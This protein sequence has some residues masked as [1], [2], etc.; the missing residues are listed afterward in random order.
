MRAPREAPGGPRGACARCCSRTERGP[1]SLMPGAAPASRRGVPPLATV[2]GERSRSPPWPSRR[3]RPPG[4]SRRRR[5][6]RALGRLPT[7]RSLPERRARPLGLAKT[8]GTIAPRCG[9]VAACAERGGAP[10][11]WACAL[12]PAGLGAH[13]PEPVRRVWPWAWRGCGASSRRGRPRVAG[14][15]GAGAR[16]RARASHASRARVQS[17]RHTPPG[18]ARPPPGPCGWR[19]PGGR[20]PRRPGAGRANGCA[21]RGRARTAPDAERA[22]RAVWWW[23]RR[24]PGRRRPPRPRPP[25]TRRPRQP[26]RRPAS[27]C[28]PGGVR[29]RRRWQRPA[30]RRRAG[31]RAGGAAAH[32]RGGLR[33]D[34]RASW[35]RPAARGGLAPGG[36]G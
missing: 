7:H 33:R 35:P 6:G 27:P 9:G 18:G 4:G 21:A 26:A 32:A 2:F 5:P 15:W 12:A 31:G 3:S 13:P 24:A 22:P 28:Q 25:P 17:G 19:H 11:A 34:A 36:R 14:P 30:P 16:P 23:G 10:C 8:V 1:P 29:V 20:S